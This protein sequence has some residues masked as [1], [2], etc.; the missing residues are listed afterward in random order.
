LTIHATKLV[1]STNYTNVTLTLGFIAG[2]GTYPIGIN[3]AT[4]PGATGIVIIASGSTPNTWI[5]SLTGAA[6]TLTITSLTSTRIAGTFSFTAD[7]ETGTSTTGTETVSNGVFDVALPSGFTAV[8]AANHGSTTTANLGG[9]PYTAAT[10][11]GTGST[12]AF[13]I[14]GLTTAKTVNLVSVALADTV[15]TYALGNSGIRVTVLDLASTHSWGGVTGDTGTVVIS[16]LANGRA[17]GTFSGILVRALSATDTLTVTN[18]TF[19][20]RVDAP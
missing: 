7:A 20:V 3:A 17:V 9:A 1:S 13:S 14:A 6:G 4:T 19:D 8:P 12:G 18:G 5:T 16:S 2:P 11:V 10:V 15:G